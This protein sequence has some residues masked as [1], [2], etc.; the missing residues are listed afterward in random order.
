MR[1]RD[2]TLAQQLEEGL[3][4]FSRENRPLPGIHTSANRTALIEQLLESIHRVTYIL[5]IAARDVSERR[6]DPNDELFDP[7]KAAI[8]H[9]RRGH[10][11]E[12]F[13][14]VFIFVHFGKHAVAG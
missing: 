3:I 2:H 6:A 12:A 7:L 5:R 13:W 10:I 1:P 4:S 9:Q 11:D 8:L 14:L